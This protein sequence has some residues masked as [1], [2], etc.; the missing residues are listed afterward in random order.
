MK[1]SKV[2]ALLA[3]LTLFASTAVFATTVSAEDPTITEGIQLKLGATTETTREIELYYVG[4]AVASYNDIAYRMVITG[5]GVTDAKFAYDTAALSNGT[6]NLMAIDG[7]Y[8]FGFATA[9]SPVKA[10]T[11]GDKLGTVTLTLAEDAEIVAR[12]SFYDIYDE[13]LENESL[14]ITEEHED[15]ASYADYINAENSF[16]TVPAF[17]TEP[18]VTYHKDVTAD[19]V[20]E[21]TELL[22]AP[23][24]GYEATV[25]YANGTVGKLVWSI[26]AA[27]Q[28]KTVDATAAEVSGQPTVIY[29]LIIVDANVDKVDEVVLKNV[30]E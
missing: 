5:A 14:W 8:Q 27:E 20:A 15:Y 4:D 18:E 21:S 13:A 12:L 11:S 17:A 19:K 26:T 28:T 2:M 24:R 25:N 6:P 23:A 22:N 10:M 16:I 7:G 9:N 3:T 1:N 29:G 30:V